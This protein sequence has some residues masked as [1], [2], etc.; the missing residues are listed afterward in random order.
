MYN[1]NLTHNHAMLLHIYLRKML[2][3]PFSISGPRLYGR[4]LLHRVSLSGELHKQTEKNLS[5]SQA[6]ITIMHAGVDKFIPSFLSQ[7]EASST[8]PPSP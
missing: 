6:R 8:P 7:V 3:S 1:N 4:W 2:L 5:R